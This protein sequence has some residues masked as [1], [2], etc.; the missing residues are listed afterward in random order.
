ML[1]LLAHMCPS[2]LCLQ[3][4]NQFVLYG[5]L[6]KPVMDG[7]QTM[8]ENLVPEKPESVEETQSAEEDD[9]TGRP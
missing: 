5:S 4:T 1:L 2:A 6:L 9:I 7:M 3:A 8:T